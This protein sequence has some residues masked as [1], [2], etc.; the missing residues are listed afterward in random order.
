MNAPRHPQPCPLK[1]QTESSGE[2]CTLTVPGDNKI[3]F[4]PTIGNEEHSW[5]MPI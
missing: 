2:S 3:W 5:G 4:Y 1:E